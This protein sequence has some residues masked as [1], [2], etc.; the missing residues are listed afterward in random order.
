MNKDDNE[1]EELLQIKRDSLNGSQAKRTRDSNN[2][3]PDPTEKV[4]EYVEPEE[5]H[6]LFDNVE[7]EDAIQLENE[8]SKNKEEETDQP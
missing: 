5:G 1:L 6:G 4:N 2:V 3:D 7:L 8:D